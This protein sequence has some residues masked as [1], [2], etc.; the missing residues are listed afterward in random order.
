MT[1]RTVEILQCSRCGFMLDVERNEHGVYV[2]PCPCTETFYHLIVFDPLDNTRCTLSQFLH[3]EKEVI[4]YAK[5]AKLDPK[6]T[7]ISKCKFL[8]FTGY[9]TLDKFGS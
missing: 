6:L 3:S 7:G 4:S 8:E 9:T 1:K 2:K 5:M